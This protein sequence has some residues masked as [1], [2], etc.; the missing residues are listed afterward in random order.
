[1]CPLCHSAVWRI[2]LA[3]VLRS[4]GIGITTWPCT[5]T[6]S[7]SH[8][9]PG[10]EDSRPVRAIAR[11]AARSAL[12][13]P[14]RCPRGWGARV[15]LN[16]G[17][18]RK[19]FECENFLC[20]GNFSSGAEI[21]ETWS[22]AGLKQATAWPALPT[23]M[24]PDKTGGNLHNGHTILFLQHTVWHGGIPTATLSWNSSPTGSP[25]SPMM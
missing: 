24:K 17:R 9:A 10:S 18:D 25:R 8:P 2:A 16:L 1:M 6:L 4:A 5:P 7:T 20:S 21:F 12:P 13:V 22:K 19:I 14:G 11:P 15:R 3:A 23:R